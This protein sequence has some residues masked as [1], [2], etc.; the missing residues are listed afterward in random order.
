M[1]PPETLKEGRM[2]DQDDAIALVYAETNSPAPSDEESDDSAEE[3][4][5]GV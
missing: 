3:E 4:E 1:H 2:I 5:K